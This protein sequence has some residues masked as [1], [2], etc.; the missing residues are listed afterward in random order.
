[1]PPPEGPPLSTI[2][3]LQPAWLLHR[4]D[5]RNTSLL[6]DVFTRDFGRRGLVAK[7]AR[8]ARGGSG[9]LLQAFRPLLLSWSGRGELGTLTGIEPAPIATAPMTTAPSATAP[10]A[11]APS[12]TPHGPAPPAPTPLETAT[13]QPGPLLCGFYLNELLIR[14]LARDDPHLALFAGYGKGIAALTALAAKESPAPTLRE[15]ELTLLTELGYGLVLDHSV[16]D[17]QAIAA[18]RLYHYVIDQ[19][20]LA[21]AGADRGIPLQG[22]TLI[23]LQ[24]GQLDAI[25]QRQ[26]RT[27]IRAALAPQLGDRPLRSRDLYRDWL[28]LQAAST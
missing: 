2:V 27:L 3:Q 16:D 22:S 12:A 1:M 24:T 26:A 15:F 6:L 13:L 18:D 11:T 23:G 21:L 14:L 20:P 28:Q 5:Y 17:G 25:G 9:P 4:R 7:G 8:R 10:S 19:G